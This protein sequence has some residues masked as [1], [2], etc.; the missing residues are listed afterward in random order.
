[1]NVLAGGVLLALLSLDKCD[2]MSFKLFRIDLRLRF[3]AFLSQFLRLPVLSLL[4][5]I[6]EH[7]AEQDVQEKLFIS[8]HCSCH[9]RISG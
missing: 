8:I 9:Q 1:M 3:W 7:R 5:Q 4:E 2:A 6:F